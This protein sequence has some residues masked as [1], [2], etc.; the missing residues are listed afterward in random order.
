MFRDGGNGVLAAHNTLKQDN[1]I[2]IYSKVTDISEA[3]HHNA[4][5]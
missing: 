5:L 3:S 4:A 1:T 2:K